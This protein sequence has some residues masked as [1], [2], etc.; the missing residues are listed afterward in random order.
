MTLGYAKE[1]VAVTCGRLVEAL[2]AMRGRPLSDEEL[3]CWLQLRR[4]ALR[5]AE[6]FR[7]TGEE[8]RC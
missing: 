6:V 1:L 3:S 8:K 7:V 4:V 2:D 5:G